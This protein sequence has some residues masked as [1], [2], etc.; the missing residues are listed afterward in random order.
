VSSLN[1][2]FS[3]GLV[4]PQWTVKDEWAGLSDSEVGR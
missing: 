2:L 1:V 3:P 4:F